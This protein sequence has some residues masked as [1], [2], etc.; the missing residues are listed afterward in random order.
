M[1]HHSKYDPVYNYV[2]TKHFLPVQYCRQLILLT[3]SKF[4]T[5]FALLGNAYLGVPPNPCF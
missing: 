2:L 4:Y 3:L 1:C 5:S